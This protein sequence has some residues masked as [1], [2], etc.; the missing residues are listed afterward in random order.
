MAAQY[1]YVM[2]DLTKTFPGAP[3]PVLNNISLQ[4]YQG[5]KIGI[6]GPNGVGKS[7]LI[8]I[9]AGVDT[10]YVGRGLVGREYLGRLPGPGADAGRVQDGAG[11]RPRRVRARRPPWSIAS[12]RSAS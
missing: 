2:K 4:F 11:E 10:E 1:A 6:V 12:T 7:T 8:K 5:A 3:K 9:M